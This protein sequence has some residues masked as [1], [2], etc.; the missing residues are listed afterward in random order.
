MVENPSN[1]LI[2]RPWKEKAIQLPTPER[3][4]EANI[5]TLAAIEPASN[6]LKQN[7]PVHLIEWEYASETILLADVETP[8]KRGLLAQFFR[9]N[10]TE[11]SENLGI[12]NARAENSDKE[13]KDTGFVKFLGGSLAVFNTI[14]GSDTELVK[15]YDN[16]GNLRNYSLEGQTF[17]VNRKLPAEKS[18]N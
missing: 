3:F 9:K 10:V 14:T 4:E 8:K 17:V 11:V 15:N 2:L 7:M 18:S 13:K 16:E 6:L 12:D 1:Q 5:Q